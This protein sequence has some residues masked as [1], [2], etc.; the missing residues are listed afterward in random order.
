MSQ[1]LTATYAAPF[2]KDVVAKIAANW[3]PGHDRA[4]PGDRLACFTVAD[5]EPA[6]REHESRFPDKPASRSSR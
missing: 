1:S 2:D 5:D 3:K 6:K 4:C